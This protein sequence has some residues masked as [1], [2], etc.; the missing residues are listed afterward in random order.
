MSLTLVGHGPLPSHS[1]YVPDFLLVVEDGGKEA[2][3]TR[4][5]L[6]H[7]PVPVS[8]SVG[9]C[10]PEPVRDGMWPLVHVR[11][12]GTELEWFSL[13]D[14]AR[15]RSERA[16]AVFAGASSIVK[17]RPEEAVL[18]LSAAAALVAVDLKKTAEELAS[19]AMPGESLTDAYLRTRQ[20]SK[21]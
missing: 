2:S 11:E 8:L 13:S 14:E 17:S 7:A 15:F 12:D 6:H 21:R 3:L 10:G 4:Q 1:P 18:L 16:K 19:R 20:G 9:R 5:G